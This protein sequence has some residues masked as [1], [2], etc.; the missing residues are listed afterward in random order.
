MRLDKDKQHRVATARIFQNFGF[1]TAGKLLGDVFVFVMFVLLSREFGKQGIGEYSFAMAITSL[2]MIL[3]NYGLTELCDK[4]MS[5][6]RE[7]RALIVK[8]YSEILTVRLVFIVLAGCLLFLISPL[9]GLSDRALQVLILVGSFQIIYTVLEGLG[10]IFVAYEKMQYKGLLE[11]SARSSSALICIAVVYAGGGLAESL[12]AL[13]VITVFHIIAVHI[14]LVRKTGKLVLGIAWKR[15]VEIVKE[16]TAYA[17]FLFLWQVAV[18]ADVI[19]IGLMLGVVAAGVYNVAYRVVF[20]LL[21]LPYFG[22][23]ALLPVASR[24][25]KSSDQELELEKLYHSSLNVAVLIGVPIAAGIWLIAPALIELIFGNEFTESA[26]ILRLLALLL[27]F[28]CFNSVAGMFLTATDRQTERVRIQWTIAWVGILGNLLLIPLLGMKGAA[29]ATIFAEVLLAVL[30]ACRLRSAFGWPKIGFR[31]SVAILGALSF[32]VSLEWWSPLPLFI[33]IP[34][35]VFIYVII[36][37]M[38]RDIR[39]KEG[40]M[41][42]AFFKK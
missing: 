5:R 9:L 6:L 7:S 31:L 18:R 8:Y 25:Y 23:T 39:V 12:I 27:F 38:F 21:F 19:L 2:L 3:A 24:L 41:I 22:A 30:L 13:P 32:S 11:F 17:G 26:Q 15:F 34:L 42:L 37:M 36:L 10:S 29:Y 40:N 4:E 33:T 35:A 1:L 14:L 16:A 28:A 20:M